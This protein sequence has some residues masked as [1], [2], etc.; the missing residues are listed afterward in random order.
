MGFIFRAAERLEAISL[1]DTHPPVVCQYSVMVKG[2]SIG[3]RI[4]GEH[5][6]VSCIVGCPVFPFSNT[7]EY[8]CHG[9]MP[10][11]SLRIR[12]GHELKETIKE[13]LYTFARD[14]ELELLIVENALSIPVH[15]P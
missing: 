15:L 1:E 9:V 7:S 12:I 13:G 5:T 14:F 4:Q 2:K 8:D 11:I 6:H 3:K 10:G